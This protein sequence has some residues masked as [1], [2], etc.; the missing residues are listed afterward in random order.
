MNVTTPE[1]ESICRQAA[2][3]LNKLASA[4]TVDVR[5]DKEGID[6]N[7]VS[8]VSKIGE[9]FIPMNELIDIEKE[10]ERLEKERKRWEGEVARANGKLNNQGFMAKAPE[11]V[12]AEERAKLA[13]A[14]EML[15]KLNARIAD[16]KQ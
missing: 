9:A 6:R 13:N 2:A 14:Q 3:Y 10:L 8:V 1:N 16:M 15:E 11:K 12:V 5:F 4:S 7:A